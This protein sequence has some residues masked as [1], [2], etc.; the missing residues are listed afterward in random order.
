M[1][2][3]RCGRNVRTSAEERNFFR[4]MAYYTP[5]YWVR[6]QGLDETT[7]E[8]EGL[9]PKDSEHFLCFDCYYDLMDK[10]REEYIKNK[11]FGPIKIKGTFKEESKMKESKKLD[12]MGRTVFNYNASVGWSASNK[13][14]AWHYFRN[15]LEDI[16]AT[17]TRDD[18]V[19]GCSGE[20]RG[21]SFELNYAFSNKEYNY[22]IDV[23]NV[24]QG[25]IQDQW[26]GKTLGEFKEDF[27]EM[28]DIYTSSEEGVYPE[29]P[30]TESVKLNEN[31]DPVVIASLVAYIGLM[32]AA[33]VG[34]GKA[35]YKLIQQSLDK[36]EEAGVEEN[37]AV[38]ISDKIKGCIEKLRNKL[39]TPTTE[40]DKFGLTPEE[41]DAL[42]VIIDEVVSSKYMGIATNESLTWAVLAKVHKEQP[43]MFYKLTHLE[44]SNPLD[45][46]AFNYALSKTS[47]AQYDKVKTLDDE[48]RLKLHNKGNNKVIRNKFNQELKSEYG[49]NGLSNS[50]YNRYIRNNFKEAKQYQGNE[51]IK[52][53][54]Y[55]KYLKTDEG[56]DDQTIEAF[57]QYLADEQNFYE[58]DY[59]E[60]RE[61]LEWDDFLTLFDDYVNEE[62][63][64]DEE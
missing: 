10:Q 22:T 37:S 8:A 1:K 20:L 43:D 19:K 9:D 24:K 63:E 59:N 55:L 34:T 51:K 5:M 21:L 58:E 45:K 25:T 62:D 53:T 33:L 52:F 23:F 14:Y 18:G 11:D 47:A 26:Q 60:K 36:A 41:L 6:D 28:K 27:Q 49:I 17:F 40:A 15:F 31:T 32:G 54:T 12:E 35:A 48:T 2:C 50:Q 13:T 57:K 39:T 29:D 7:C 64:D 16:G 44:G 30:L 38:S 56:L 46:D 42:D 61:V 4:G 3:I